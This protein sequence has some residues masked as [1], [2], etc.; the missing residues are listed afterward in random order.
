MKDRVYIS[1]L[2]DFYSELLTDKQR[3]YFEDYYFND[4]SLNE[5]AEKFSITK[6]GVRESLVKTENIL[7][8][9]EETLSLNNKHLLRKHKIDLIYKTIDNLDLDIDTKHDLKKEIS[10]IE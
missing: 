2:Y 9:Y 8:N 4:L 1:I 10:S 3:V 5:I 6:Q 7:I